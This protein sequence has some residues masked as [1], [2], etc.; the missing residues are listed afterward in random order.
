MA[1]VGGGGQ[2]GARDRARAPADARP[3]Q[4]RAGRKPAAP[5]RCSRPPTTRSSRRPASDP[6]SGCSSTAAPAASAR[7]R[8][9]SDAQRGRRCMRP[10]ATKRCAI[11]VADLGATVLAPE[12]FAEHG[13]FDVILELVGA[14]NMP[15]NVNA[16]EHTRPDHGDRDRRRRQGRGPPRRADGQARTDLRLDDPLP[17][18]RGEGADGARDRARSPAAARQRRRHGPDRRDVPARRRSIR[19]TTDSPPAASSARSS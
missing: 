17:A 6:A 2:S 11:G 8:S 14:P 3:G 5:P 1:I 9:S 12:G 19:P 13:P 18:A 4:P 15:D 7:R 10:C 16:A